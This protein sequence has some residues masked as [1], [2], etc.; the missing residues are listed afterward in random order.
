MSTQSIPITKSPDLLS[1]P[2]VAAMIGRGEYA[3]RKALRSGE[4]PGIMFCGRWTVSRLALQ[5]WI[6]TLGAGRG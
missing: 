1:V 4:I 2:E 5:R 6:E 3:V